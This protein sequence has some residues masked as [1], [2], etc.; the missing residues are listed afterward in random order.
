[1]SKKKEIYNSN[2]RHDP[3]FSAKYEKDRSYID[4]SKFEEY[5]EE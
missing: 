4:P 5:T 1:M 3:E 2:K